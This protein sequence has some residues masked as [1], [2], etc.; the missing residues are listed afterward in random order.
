MAEGTIGGTKLSDLPASAYAY[1]EPG[2]AAPPTRCH[3]PIRDA[4]GKLDEAHVRNALA[5]LDQ[6]PFGAKARAAVEAAARKLGIGEPAGKAMLEMKAAPLTSRQYESWLNGEIPRRILPVPFY[7]PIP[8]PTGKVKG[9]DLDGEYFDAQT[10]LFGPF[11]GLR[12]SRWRAI[13]WH[14]DDR[15]VPSPV[16][17]GPPSMKGVLIGEMQLD[18]EPDDDGLW[19]DWWIKQGQARRDLVARRIAEIERR[20]QPLFNSTQAVRGADRIGADGHIEVWPIYRNTVSTSAQNQYAVVPPLKAVLGDFSSSD[21][22]SEALG[23]LLVGIDALGSDLA[24]TYPGTD[25]PGDGEPAAKAGRVLSAKNE[26]AL[27]QAIADL[28][29]REDEF[30]AWV[31]GLLEKGIASDE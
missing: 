30:E 8:D 15:G 1:C 19:A 18:T 26:A 11:P 17:G 6:S 29:A 3:F 10:D 7:G 4:N 2:D 14:H 27:R 23:A 24:A 31:N 16:V 9:K 13:D 21:L 28:R 5:R 20:G 12:A 25:A 22:T